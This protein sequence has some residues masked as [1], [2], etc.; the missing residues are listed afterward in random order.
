MRGHEGLVVVALVVCGMMIWWTLRAWLSRR[1][2]IYDTQVG[3]WYGRYGAWTR[4]RR[5][6]A[7]YKSRD[8]A[9]EVLEDLENGTVLEDL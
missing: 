5:Q 1:W 8:F 4:A 2:V 3:C 6:R 7:L 9:Q